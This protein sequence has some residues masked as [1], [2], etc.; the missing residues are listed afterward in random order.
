MFFVFVFVFARSE[1]KVLSVFFMS[2]QRKGAL[3][4]ILVRKESLQ[5][6][7]FN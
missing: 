1:L 5:I 7:T 3:V 6:L 2:L 4:Y